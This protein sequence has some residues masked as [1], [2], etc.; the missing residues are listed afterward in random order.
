[1]YDHTGYNSN[2]HQDQ[3]STHNRGYSR[4]MSRKCHRHFHLRPNK[5]YHDY[6]QLPGPTRP[7]RAAA[8]TSAASCAPLWPKRFIT[9]V[10]VR[11]HAGGGG[12]KNQVG[13]TPSAG[14]AQRGFECAFWGR[15]SQKR[16]RR[17]IF[18]DRW[19][20]RLCPGAGAKR[21]R[22][23]AAKMRIA[24]VLFP[25]V[26]AKAVAVNISAIWAPDRSLVLTKWPPLASLVLS[27][28]EAR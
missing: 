28:T 6:L 17:G 25:D 19:A 12:A 24:G 23:R 18:L 2:C 15:C 7:R 11:A 10:A 3:A 1:M 8:P 20:E 9:S 5:D 22:G 13:A 27:A 26:L 21:N 14:G 4:C 16:R